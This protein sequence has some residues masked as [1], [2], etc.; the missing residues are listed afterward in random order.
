VKKNWRGLLLEGVVLAALQA[1]RFSP[2]YAPTPE[3]W[4]WRRGHGPDVVLPLRKRT[5]AIEAKNWGGYKVTP[6]VVREE[7][8]SRFSE[9]A[10]RVLVVSSLANWT[11]GAISLLD[12]CAVIAIEIGFALT[13][14]TLGQAVAI[15]EARLAQLL[16]ISP[17]TRMHGRPH[18]LRYF[19]TVP[20]S[21]M[22]LPLPEVAGDGSV[23]PAGARVIG[24]PMLGVVGAPLKRPASSFGFLIIAR[25]SEVKRGNDRRS[26][27]EAVWRTNEFGD[28]GS[29]AVAA[30]G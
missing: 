30:T 22:F 19:L 16:G 20:P 8:L 1:L 4:R 25:E 21:C 23:K 26:G 27:C 13:P 11:T 24:P 17:K 6:D 3:A 18:E 10:V 28:C 9:G 12:E 2:L 7:V 29:V 5:I 14:A 15:L